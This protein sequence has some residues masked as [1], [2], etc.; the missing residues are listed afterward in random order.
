MRRLWPL[1]CSEDVR[2]GWEERGGA[3][4]EPLAGLDL[5]PGLLDCCGRVARH[6]AAARDMR[7]EGGVGEPLKAGLPRGVGDDV[8]VEAQL[9]ARADDDEAGLSNGAMGSTS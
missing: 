1:G 2:V 4:W 6:V 8:L 5:K 7:P 3:E 9:T